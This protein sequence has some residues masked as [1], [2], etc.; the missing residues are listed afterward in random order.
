VV[1]D[2][3]GDDVGEGEITWGV[4]LALHVLEEGKIEVNVLVPR[5]IKRAHG[6]AVVAAGR[7]DLTREQ[8]QMRPSIILPHPLELGIPDVLGVGQ[9]YGDEIAH[10]PVLVAE[11]LAALGGRQRP[12]VLNALGDIGRVAAEQEVQDEDYNATHAPDPP[13]DRQAPAAD[14]PPVH[15]VIALPSSLPFHVRLPSSAILRKKGSAGKTPP[16]L[17]GG[18]AEL[19][20]TSA[21]LEDVAFAED[22]P[23][24]ILVLDRGHRV[25]G[26]GRGF[27]MDGA[28]QDRVEREA[29]RLVED[30]LLNLDRSEKI[31]YA[32]QA[33]GQQGVITMGSKTVVGADDPENFDFQTDLKKAVIEEARKKSGASVMENP[34][35]K[36][37]GKPIPNY[38][39]KRQDGSAVKLYDLLEKKV[40]MLVVFISPAN[41]GMQAHYNGVGM[42]LKTA[43]SIYDNIALGL[44]GPGKTAVPNAFP[45]S[46]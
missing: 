28:R 18:R 3:V 5:T 20:Y 38:S 21:L 23:G 12:L 44:A 39:L 37:L 7:I 1:A 25:R 43:R 26:F 8:D 24:L 31:T 32:V 4:Q 40:T 19:N 2:L 16:P 13:S 6:R 33:V 15:D 30:L 29:N 11:R 46:E 27:I 22:M 35:F 9:N 17:V 36:Y 34:F 41:K 45:D 14:P 10:L 42:T